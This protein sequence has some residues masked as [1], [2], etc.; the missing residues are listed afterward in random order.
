VSSLNG[1]SRFFAALFIAV[2]KI[3]SLADFYAAGGPVVV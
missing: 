3:S 1:W 2:L